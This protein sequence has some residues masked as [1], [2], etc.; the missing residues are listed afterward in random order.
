MHEALTERRQRVEAVRSGTAG[1]SGT[2]GVVA[3]EVVA[4]W[5][6]SQPFVDEH[7]G[8]V[9]VAPD[10]LVQEAWDRSPIRRLG[11]GALDELAAIADEEDYVAAVTDESGTILWCHGGRSMRRR[12]EAVNFVRGGRWGEQDAGTNALGLALTSGRPASVFSA[13]HWCESV[14]DWVCYSAPV[15]DPLTGRPLGVLDLSSTWERSSGLGLT[16]VRALARLVTN[17]L[18]HAGPTAV[19]AWHL[20]LLGRGELLHHGD[21]VR[22]SG[23]QAEILAVLA[24]S[25]GLTLDQLHAHVY[26]DRPVSASTLKAEV[27]HLRKLLGGG[28]AARPYRLTVPMSVDVEE[29]LAAVEGHDVD[30]ALQWYRG[31]VLPTTDAPFLAAFGYHVEASLEHAVGRWGSPEQ[32]LAF[33]RRHVADLL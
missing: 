10:E 5:R 8:S 20:R 21:P 33:D 30:W 4:S 29:L 26:G 27:S 2:A 1:S 31:P 9:P 25:D 6:R 17:E 22:L 11:A 18:A 12:G 15:L 14:A 7:Q 32:R 16:T 3:D 28:I 19:P 13:E 24:L 23:R